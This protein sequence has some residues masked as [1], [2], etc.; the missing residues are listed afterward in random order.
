MDRKP[1]PTDG[2]PPPPSALGA[3]SHA[4]E[5]AAS[6]AGDVFDSVTI[7]EA[8]KMILKVWGLGVGVW[9]LGFGVGG[10]GFRV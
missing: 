8:D 2:P 5:S 3:T 7:D 6:L 1:Q 10:S 4:S 9:G